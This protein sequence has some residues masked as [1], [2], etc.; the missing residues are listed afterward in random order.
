MGLSS[1]RNECGATFLRYVKK[2][3]RI[4]RYSMDRDGLIIG[5]GGLLLL[6]LTYFAGVLRTERRHSR[7]DS[8][9]RIVKVLDAYIAASRVGRIN[10]FPGLVQAGIATL[11]ND[12]EIRSLMERIVQYDQR[13]DPRPVLQGVDAHEFFKKAVESQYD[14]QLSGSAEA[15]ASR[16]RSRVS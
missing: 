12:A 1:A 14:F 16:L 3:N 9:A 5:F 13:W 4:C 6:A 2:A 7:S 11:E 8:E 15:L 10:G